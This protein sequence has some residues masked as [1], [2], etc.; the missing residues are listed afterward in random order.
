MTDIVDNRITDTMSYIENPNS[1]FDKF[2]LTERDL[3]ISKTAAPAKIAVPEDKNLYPSAN[4]FIVRLNEDSRL[5][6][7]YLKCYLESEGGMKLLKMLQ[8]GGS[9]PAFTKGNLENL[10]IPYKSKQ[11]QDILEQKYREYENTILKMEK[12]ICL[13]RK[14][15]K[16]LI[17]DNG[18]KKQYLW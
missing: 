7:Y 8:S 18:E 11:D 13:A 16:K 4:F 15:Q 5:N 10:E 6:R 3:I 14:S 12:E 1:D 9:L 17:S 2:R